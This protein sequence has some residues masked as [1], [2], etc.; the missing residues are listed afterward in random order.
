[1]GSTYKIL[2]ALFIFFIYLIFPSVASATLSFQ[3]TQAMPNIIH[4]QEE[5]VAV[6]L[7]I[8][9]LPSESYFRVAFQ[10]SDGGD[11]F[12]Y[13]KNELGVW[14]KINSLSGDCSG[15]Y[16]VSDVATTTIQ[17]VLKVGN[18]NNPTNGMY[19]IRGHRL[20]TSCSSNTVSSEGSPIEVEVSLPTPTPTATPTETPTPDPTATSTPTVTPTSTPAKTSTPAATKTATPKPK[21]PTPTPASS[22][23]INLLGEETGEFNLEDITPIPQP[24]VLGA[25]DTA[26]DNNKFFIPFVFIGTGVVFL[27]LGAFTFLKNKPKDGNQTTT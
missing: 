12:G 8:T 20:T 10:K 22:P 19:R 16:K 5:E 25:K 4:T 21:T 24:E 15:Y 7:T 9:D 2:S 27:S 13:I 14:T 26:A 18:D 11:Y 23:Q 3:V 1:M 17:I 6:N